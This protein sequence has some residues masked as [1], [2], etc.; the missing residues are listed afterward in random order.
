M[1]TAEFVLADARMRFGE[2]GRLKL[3][4]SNA[5]VQVFGKFDI[6]VARYIMDKQE[7]TQAVVF[8]NLLEICNSFVLEIQRA[9][10]E[11]SD[12]WEGFGEKT[13]SGLEVK[14]GEPG[15]V[16]KKLMK[17]QALHAKAQMCDASSTDKKA[18]L[19]LAQI[20]AQGANHITH[21]DD[22]AEGV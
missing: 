17:T 15:Q 9:K 11:A 20:D 18:S 6:H 2:A 12:D 19:P 14:E 13:L 10:G 4:E 21:L 8:K 16:S 3:L 7:S 1:R 22:S 5:L